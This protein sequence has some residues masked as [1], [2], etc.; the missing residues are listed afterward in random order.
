MNIVVIG[1]GAMGSIYGGRLSQWNE[2]TLVDTNEALV[3]KVSRDGVT[4]EEGGEERTFHP[5]AGTDASAAGTADLVILFT[6]ALYSVSALEN[7]RGAIGPDTYLMTLQNGAGHERVLSAFADPS[8]IIIGT[9]EDNGSVLSLGHVHHG[10]EGVTNIGRLDGADDP[11]LGRVK[12]SFDSCGFDVRIHGNIQQLVWDKL[13]TNVSLS[14][15]TAVLQCDMG[16]IYNDRYARDLCTQL[17]KEAVV[18]ANAQGLG[19]DEEAALAKVVS[20]S[21]SNPGAYTS[22]MKDIA[23]GRRTEVDT[24]RGEVVSAA[25]SLGLSVP[26]HEMIVSLIHAME[27]RGCQGSSR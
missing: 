24:N 18:V 15:L 27:G 10:G 22:I 13:M 3:E 25:H 4:L 6:K 5:S 17:V 11:F 16:Y 14:A 19:F 26:H 1:A 20:V 21:R 23:A 9:T 2:V 7:V 8:H 12:E